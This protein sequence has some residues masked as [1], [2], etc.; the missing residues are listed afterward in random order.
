MTVIKLSADAADICWRFPL[1]A[2][3]RGYV[4]RYWRH[5]P[6]T[7]DDSTSQGSS[8]SSAS[9]QEL[10]IIDMDVRPDAF[11]NVIILIVV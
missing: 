11:T 4:L 7:D 2:G 1:G 6:S 5:S 10:K 9:V 3:A 8:F